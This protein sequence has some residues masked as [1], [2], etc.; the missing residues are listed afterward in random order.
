MKKLITCLGLL[1]ALSFASG[2][3]LYFGP[4]DDDDWSEP[5]PGTGWSC[6][7]DYDC[8]A[9]CYCDTGYYGDGS[10]GY[11]ECI[12][13]GYCTSDADCGWGYQCDESRSSCVPGDV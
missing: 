10:Y 8:A 2:C 3:T 5:P 11:G 4:D 9:G 7:S 13:A 1:M 6:Y 12:E